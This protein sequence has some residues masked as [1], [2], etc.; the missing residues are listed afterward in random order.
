MTPTDRELALEHA[1]FRRG[2]RRRY[3][4]WY[5]RDDRERRANQIYRIVTAVVVALWIAWIVWS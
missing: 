5:E 4:V 2:L 3:H 1:R